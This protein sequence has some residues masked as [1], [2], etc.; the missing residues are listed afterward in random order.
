[1]VSLF[2]IRSSDS[3]VK[4]KVSNE[5]SAV[6]VFRH[7]ENAEAYIRQSIDR[8]FQGN[9]EAVAFTFD[10]FDRAR[11]WADKSGIDLVLHVYDNPTTA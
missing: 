7:R 6:L 1:M 9:C 10:L 8:S 3:L 5:I 4:M 11:V 2:C